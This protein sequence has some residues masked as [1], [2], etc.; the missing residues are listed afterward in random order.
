M[1]GLFLLYHYTANDIS[2]NFTYLR[3]T[4]CDQSEMIAPPKKL[5][6]IYIISRWKTHCGFIQQ[7]SQCEN[8]SKIS[9]GNESK[10]M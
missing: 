7:P 10:Y 9:W 3:M 2:D 5:I 4:Q 1:P 6:A 8:N